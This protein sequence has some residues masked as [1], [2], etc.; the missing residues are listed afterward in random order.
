MNLPSL[1][2]AVHPLGEPKE[3]GISVPSGPVAVDTF[4]GRVQVECIDGIAPRGVVATFYRTSAGAE[5]DLVLEVPGGD[6]WAV[7]IKLGLSPKPGKGF[8]IACEDLKASRAFV[9]Y[10]GGERYPLGRDVQAISLRGLCEELA[11]V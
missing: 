4:G 9:V 3:G 10:S 2:K 1:P 5:V 6:V 8:H 11:R 7:E